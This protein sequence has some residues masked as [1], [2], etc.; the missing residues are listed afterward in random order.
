MKFICTFASEGERDVDTKR[1]CKECRCVPLVCTQTTRSSWART[2]L[3]PRMAGMQERLRS[4]APNER[5]MK[6]TIVI[7]EQ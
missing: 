6:I 1:M 5:K 4:R 2:S 7:W 3:P